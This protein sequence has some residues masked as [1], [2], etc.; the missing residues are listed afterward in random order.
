M[1][2]T[3]GK[4]VALLAVL[5]L[6]ALL[7]VDLTS[8]P[9][10]PEAAAAPR[11]AEQRPD[12]T[13]ARVLAHEQAGGP[14]SEELVR[15]FEDRLASVARK[16]RW[17]RRETSDKLLRMHQI[18]EEEVGSYSYWISPW[19]STTLRPALQP[20]V[21]NCWR[22]SGQSLGGP[23][24][25]TPS[26][27]SGESVECDCFY[28][29]RPE[30]PWFSARARGRSF[31]ATCRSVKQMVKNRCRA[32]DRCRE[33]AWQGR[34]ASA[35]STYVWRVTCAIVAGTQEIVQGVD[36]WPETRKSAKHL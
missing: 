17:S 8:G 5:A 33:Q 11:I 4:V 32:A 21:M 6:V 16:C 9:D 10:E 26:C 23:S 13:E 15:T 36:R 29:C 22:P 25:S 7:S 3:P 31:T 27:H 24:R 30:D 34:A 35:S 14:P 1:N 28:R 18:L 20:T 2:V 12:R 19:A